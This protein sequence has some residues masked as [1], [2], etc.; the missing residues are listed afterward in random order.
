MDYY[1][2]QSMNRFKNNRVDNL[3]QKTTGITIVL[4]LGILFLFLLTSG[5]QAAAPIPQPG[6]GFYVLDE[7][8][9]LS[10]ETKALIVGTSE[11]LAK[12][13]KAQVAVVTVKSLNDQPVE[14]L[15]LSILR[16]W[17]LGDKELNNGLI[18]LVAPVERKMRIE[19]GYGLEGRL[20][21]A[22]TGR[23]RDEYMLPAFQKGNY[24]QGIRQGY[25]VIVKEVAQEYNVNINLSSDD[26]ATNTATKSKIPTWASIIGIII[27]LVLVWFDY[28][29]LNGFLFGF[30]LGMLFRGGFGGGGGGGSGGDDSGGGGSGGGGGSS[31][32]W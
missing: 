26:R 8:N 1:L 28:R 31:G 9:V 15:A 7:A 30:L 25:S 2:L 3:G 10:P 23:I 11:N 13:T 24:D 4:L 27:L 32:S 5:V 14:E 19:V 12:Q 20:P 29:Y 18:I 17:K 6:P 16:D 22:K 21:D